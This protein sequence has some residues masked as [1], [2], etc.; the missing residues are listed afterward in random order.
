M[1]R[2]TAP[3]I[4]DLTIIVL[5]SSPVTRI[6]RS[7]VRVGAAW[8]ASCNGIETWLAR[9]ALVSQACWLI[10]N[11]PAVYVGSEMMPTTSH[12]S[13]DTFLTDVRY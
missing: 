1:S 12:A 7:V 13:I 6:L 3:G 10:S 4:W 8:R 9:G 2:I 11:R 5:A